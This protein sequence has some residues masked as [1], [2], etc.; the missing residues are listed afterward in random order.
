MQAVRVSPCD[1]E[2]IYYYIYVYIYVYISSAGQD[3]VARKESL[4]YYGLPNFLVVESLPMYALVPI[5]R[6][7][8]DHLAQMQ[9]CEMYKR[10]IVYVARLWTCEVCTT[11]MQTA[12]Y[13]IYSQLKADRYIFISIWLYDTF[14]L[15]LNFNIFT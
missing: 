8:F 3:T 6:E 14:L 11:Y 13:I 7:K 4:L 10:H 1:G 12:Y 15:F 2:R 9:I 5:G